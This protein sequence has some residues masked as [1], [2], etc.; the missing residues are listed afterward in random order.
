MRHRSTVNSRVG[1]T[2]FPELGYDSYS[3]VWLA[4]GRTNN[5]YVVNIIMAD[6]SKTSPS[7][8]FSINFILNRPIILDVNISLVCWIFFLSMAQMDIMLAWLVMSPG[9]VFQN[10]KTAQTL[11]SQ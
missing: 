1:V 3:T 5:R 10:P 11:C 4:R 8:K 9:A 2:N 7:L 6:S